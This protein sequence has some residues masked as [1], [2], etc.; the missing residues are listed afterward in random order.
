LRVSVIAMRGI[1]VA[2]LLAGTGCNLVFELDPV[3]GLQ[4]TAQLERRFL[5]GRSIEDRPREIVSARYLV[6][7]VAAATGYRAE[8]ALIVDGVIGSPTR[9]PLPLLEVQVADVDFPVYFGLDAPHVHHLSTVLGPATRDPVFDAAV[10]WQVALSSPWDANDDAR[11]ASFGVWGEVPNEELPP[12]AGATL[13]DQTYRWKSDKVELSNGATFGRLTPDDAL[14]LAR[15]RTGIVDRVLIDTEVTSFD[16]RGDAVINGTMTA[17]MPRTVTIAPPARPMQDR[18]AA[19]P[20][21]AATPA[22]TQSSVRAIPWLTEG[23]RLGLLLGQTD[24]PGAT[25]ANFG[26]PRLDDLD[27]TPTFAA[28]TVAGRGADGTPFIAIGEQLT[29]IGATDTATSAELSA[30]FIETLIVNGSTVVDDLGLMLP[31]GP[32]EVSWFPDPN[33]PA[34]DLYAVTLVERVAADLSLVTRAALL[35][36]DTR[37]VIPGELIVAGTYSIQI[38]T[39]TGLPGAATGDLV[40]Q[41]PTRGAAF[42]PGP[43]FTIGP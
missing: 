19:I 9:L 1:C 4:H 22:G 36:R 13:L 35:T 33:L 26:E 15:Y 18:V 12:V 10:R 25:S 11:L 40:T 7:D 23:N 30:P 3:D 43:L 37:I 21:F 24:V 16:Q 6:R 17:A 34:P 39:Y 14:V 32:L 8:P 42:T 5:G 31:P 2:V 29:P 20:G 27:A 41:L 38:T 28:L